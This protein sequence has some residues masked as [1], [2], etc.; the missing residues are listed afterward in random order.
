MAL[1]ILR[2]PYTPYSIY[3]RRSI[4][5]RITRFGDF[6]TLATMSPNQ[7]LWRC[8][9]QFSMPLRRRKK[10]IDQSWAGHYFPVMHLRQVELR[11]GLKLWWTFSC[12]LRAPFFTNNVC[13]DAIWVVVKIM[14]PFWVPS[15]IRHIIF[16]VP[17]K[18]SYF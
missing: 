9:P 7:M 4:G 18:G 1:G 3:L 8:P 17:K 13:P 15:I 11:Q 16:R 10:A 12:Y 2:S 5:L 14:V 6:H